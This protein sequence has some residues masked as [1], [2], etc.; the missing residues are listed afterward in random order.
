M[1]I[2]QGKIPWIS[3][4]ERPL[5]CSRAPQFSGNPIRRLEACDP[6]LPLNP[7]KPNYRLG[8]QVGQR[9]IHSLRAPVPGSQQRA[10]IIEGAGVS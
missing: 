8:F 9:Q 5:G 2:I 10:A 6:P 4:F 1:E 7:A 3:V